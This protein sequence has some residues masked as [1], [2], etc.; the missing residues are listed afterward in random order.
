MAFSEGRPSLRINPPGILPTEYCFSSNST[1]RG[2]KSIPSRA[3]LDIVALTSS[4]VSPQRM[5]QEPLACSAYLPISTDSLRPA[6]SV[7]NV[8]NILFSPS[9]LLKAAWLLKMVKERI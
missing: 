2:K 5:R 1:L 6:N 8:L 9:V 7:S 4:A 3:C